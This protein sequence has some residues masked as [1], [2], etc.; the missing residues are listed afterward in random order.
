[1]YADNLL[2]EKPQYTV[3]YNQSKQTANWVSHIVNETWIDGTR[4]DE[5][6]EDVTLPNNLYKVPG[7]AYNER[8]EFGY[9]RGHLAPAAD[10]ARTPKDAIAADLMTN[11]LPQN[12]ANNGGF[13]R[14]LEQLSVGEEK[15]FMSLRD[16]KTIVK[17]EIKFRNQIN[18]D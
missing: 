18:L 16:A 5:F 2:L 6:N 1:M 17:T 15:K 3:S 4:K 8:D 12:S 7:D 13:W 9:A 14:T 10:I 11:I